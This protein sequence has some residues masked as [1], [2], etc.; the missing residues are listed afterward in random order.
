MVTAALTDI[1]Q[2]SRLERIAANLLCRFKFVVALFGHE[3]CFG[4]IYTYLCG[5]QSEFLAVRPQAFM[6]DRCEPLE[7]P[8][9]LARVAASALVSHLTYWN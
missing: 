6:R 9:L 3:P 5:Q 1:G 2:V 7:N 8:G 4:R